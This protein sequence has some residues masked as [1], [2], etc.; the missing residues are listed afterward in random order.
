VRPALTSRDIAGLEAMPPGPRDAFGRI[1]ERVERSFFGGREAD[2]DDFAAA[3]RDYE[4]F[5][6]AED[7]A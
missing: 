3:R 1:A 4:A 2:A 6:F 7:W 5:A